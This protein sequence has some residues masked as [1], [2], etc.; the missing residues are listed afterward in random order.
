MCSKELSFKT[1]EE[2]DNL[3]IEF[4]KIEY[5]NYYQINF[6]INILSCQ[7]KKFNK[8]YN[9]KKENLKLNSFQFNIIE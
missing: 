7:I 2:I 4:S 5:P 6:F 9:I 3:I 1:Q 8:H